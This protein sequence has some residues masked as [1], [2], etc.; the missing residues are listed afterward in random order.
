MALCKNNLPSFKGVDV[1]SVCHA[2]AASSAAS[3]V[4]TAMRQ[5]GV[6]LSPW[7]LLPLPP[8]RLAL[9]HSLVEQSV[10]IPRSLRWKM[11]SRLGQLTDSTRQ[12]GYSMPLTARSSR[13]WI[14]AGGYCQRG[15]M[16]PAPPPR[17]R[18]SSACVRGCLLLRRMHERAAAPHA[19]GLRSASSVG[20]SSVLSSR[21][22][23]VTGPGMP[24]QNSRRPPATRALPISRTHKEAV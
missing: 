19:P 5:G 18:P 6:Y 24:V 12:A 16:P 8:S 17:W 3:L 4:V 14:V 9:R 21:L 2:R 22:T 11:R 23:P 10:A 15:V 20:R 7:P 1:A 13:Y